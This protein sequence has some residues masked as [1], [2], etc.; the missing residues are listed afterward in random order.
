MV[1]ARFLEHLLEKL[2][3]FTHRGVAVDRSREMSLT[4]LLVLLLPG[5]V[6]GALVGRLIELFFDSSGSVEDRPHR[7]LAGGMVGSDVQEFLRGPR[8]LAAQLVNRGLTC[9]PREER[10]DDVV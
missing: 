2:G 3:G 1:G 8:A 4:L 5:T 10:H 9:G 6:R 7:L